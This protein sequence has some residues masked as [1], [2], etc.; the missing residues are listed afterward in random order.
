MVI[1]NNIS[2]TLIALAISDEESLAVICSTL[3]QA[4][5]S[6]IDKK[7]FLLLKNNYDRGL[8][9]DWVIFEQELVRQGGSKD[10][11]T[12][13][14][15]I[16]VNPN[17][18]ES[19]IESMRMN[20]CASKVM[21]L[22][23]KI[24]NIISSAS[25]KDDLLAEF[26]R[27]FEMASN[28]EG[29]SDSDVLSLA[30]YMPKYILDQSEVAK[31]V[32][33]TLGIQTGLFEYDKLTSGLCRTDLIVLAGRPA[34]GKTSMA[35]SLLFRALKNGDAGLFFSLE[36]PT[37]QIVHRF[38]AMYTGIPLTNIREAKLSQRQQSA[39]ADALEFIQ[40]KLQLFCS[41]KGGITFSELR[42]KAI[43]QHK[44]SPL[45]FIIIDYLQLMSVADCDGQSKSE[46]LGIITSGL[47]TLAKE[48]DVPIIL[49]SQLSRECEQRA[50]KRPIPSDL[51]ESGAIEQ[52][53][54]LIL[55]VYRDVVY[56]EDAKEP[57]RAELIIA[58]QRNGP[59]GTVIMRFIGHNTL[60][61]NY[62]VAA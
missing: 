43:A 13:L 41:D 6:G 54:D 10:F 3:T 55:F 15:C 52:D 51:R 42:R 57:E 53:A 2:K 44:K 4:M 62:Q 28:I 7:A 37:E 24:D 17:K 50:D 45:K 36:M 35:L 49:L 30:D 58:K 23:G 11:V 21:A 9:V 8:T 29:I 26:T 19:Y 22:K 60:F 1:N 47:K 56:N 39:Y 48:L 46:K 32:G 31:S 12:S 33:K 25:N 20:T 40:S 59:S 14:Q 38:I 27:E 61:T 5:F 18:L 34:M 16:S